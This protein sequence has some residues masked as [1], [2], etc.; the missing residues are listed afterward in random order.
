VAEIASR[1]SAEAK[2]KPGGHGQ[3]DVLVD[4]ELVFSKHAVGRFP[5]DAEILA[6][7]ET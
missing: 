2:A 6:K 5:E 4:G 3:F 7:L 1:T